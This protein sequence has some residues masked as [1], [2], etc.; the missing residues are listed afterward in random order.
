MWWHVKDLQKE[1][2]EKEQAFKTFY[3][4]FQS[5]LD[6]HKE[7]MMLLEDTNSDCFWFI[8]N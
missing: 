5:E 4:K 6:E 2:E 8:I 7:Q 3:N 1:V